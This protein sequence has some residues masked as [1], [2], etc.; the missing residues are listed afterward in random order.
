VPK[1]RSCR[2]SWIGGGAEVD[3]THIDDTIRDQIELP[4]A[5]RLQ[6]LAD[7]GLIAKHDI[8]MFH[9]S[10]RQFKTAALANYHDFDPAVRDRLVTAILDTYQREIN[11]LIEGIA[12]RAPTPDHPARAATAVSGGVS[13]HSR[14]WHRIIGVVFGG[15]PT[16]THGTAGPEAQRPVDSRQDSRGDTGTH[17]T[18]QDDQHTHSC[19]HHQRQRESDEAQPPS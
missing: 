4:A 15:R 18:A 17:P 14:W 16:T 7:A 5:R 9:V 2:T 6:E 19:E 3:N 8:E 11:R 12:R 13:D 10:A 1:R